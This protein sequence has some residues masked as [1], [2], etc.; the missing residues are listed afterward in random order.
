MGHRTPLR[1]P[2]AQ[3]G[4]SLIELMVS[5]VVG[6]AIIAALA[7]LFANTSRARLE[8]EKTSQ[9]IENGRYATQYL[10]DELRM[11]GYFGEFAP[12]LLAT[13]AATPDPSLT[14][15]ASVAAAIPIG[16][17]GY[18]FG[19]TASTAGVPAGVLALLTDRKANSDVLVIRRISSCTAGPTV[20]EASCSAM[21]TS[22]YKYFQTTLCQAQLTNLAATD[23]FVL[24][25]NATVFTTT[26]AAVTSSPTFLA[27]K[28]CATAAATRA[29]YVRFYYI[30]NNDVAGDGIP[31]LKM[32]AL[33]STSFFAPVAIAEGIDSMQIE[34]GQD[35][36]ADGAPD[37][38]VTDPGALGADWAKVTA[39]K[40]R[41][42]A[43]NT[44][45]T[46]GMSDD[47]RTFIMGS[48]AG[49]DNTFGPF[50]DKYKRHMYT[51][52]VRLVNVAERFE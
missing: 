3:R 41:L 43:R 5:V 52:V 49:A 36:N 4:F 2:A 25:T 8:T 7:M 13:P 16:V 32:V 12:T 34:Y 28:D 40:V 37:V 35:T 15:D 26:N 29:V 42:L 24:G 39:V 46:L 23:Q 31:T 6:L 47:P 14:D 17:Q 50:T 1:P 33:G 10:R 38:Y 45:P 9:Q 11:A 44:Q 27:Q 30:A 18:H 20:A 21:D 19:M 48:T 22:N 51:T